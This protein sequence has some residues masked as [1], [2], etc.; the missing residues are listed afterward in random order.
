MTVELVLPCH[1]VVGESP[2][3]SAAESALYWVDIVGSRI[4]RLEVATGRHDQWL[5][6]EYPTSIGLRAAGGFIVGL[7]QRVALWTP[8]GPFETFAIPEPDRPGNRLNEGCVAPD[9]SFWVGSM[10]ENI[11]ADGGPRPMAGD[12]GRLYRID[13]TGRVAPLTDDRFG[14]TNTMVWTDDGRFVT[15]DTTR[16]ALY[17]YDCSPTAL[18][19]RRTLVPAITRGVPDG[20]T[21][22]A[23]GTIYN[24]RVGGGASIA[25]IEDDAVSFIDLPCRSPT[26][27]AFGGAG[28]AVLF[29]TSATFGLTTDEIDDNP[30]E[31]GLFALSGLGAG[32]PANLFKG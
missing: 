18:T 11:G 7:R 17:V 29:V 16:N 1:D 6:P 31:G 20:A 2:V 15:A 19:N 26:S 8:D 21:R 23:K 10:A 4:H 25:R 3:W 12:T 27:C 9:G 24:A 5:T 14:I 30:A 28:L 22:D 32:L 13:A